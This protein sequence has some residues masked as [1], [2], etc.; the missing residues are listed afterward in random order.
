MAFPTGRPNHVTF[1]CM[2]TNEDAES[3]DFRLFDLNKTG[4]KYDGNKIKTIS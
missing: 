3:C 4:T 2:T 1:S